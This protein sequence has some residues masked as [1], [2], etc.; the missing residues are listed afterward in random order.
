MEV[1]ADLELALSVA[2]R[3]SLIKAR[4]AEWYVVL[5][6]RAEAIKLL[7]ELQAMAERRYVS[8]YSLAVAYFGLGQKEKTL[9][10]LNR[11]VEEYEYH[12]LTLGVDPFFT[13]L[14]TDVRFTALLQRMRMPLP[15][16]K[17]S[18]VPRTPPD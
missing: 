9:F 17:G 10:W 6:R 15:S 4:L 1:L 18:A 12:A 2:P 5:G 13:D 8:P 3:R 14:F 16:V 7:G 11:T